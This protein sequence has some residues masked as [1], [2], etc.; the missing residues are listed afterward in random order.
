M[1][2]NIKSAPGVQKVLASLPSSNA[3]RRIDSAEPGQPAGGPAFSLSIED[4][5]VINKPLPWVGWE[6]GQWCICI[7]GGAGFKAG[8]GTLLT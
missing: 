6:R 4:K 5:A 2:I 1:E 7:G 3:E 8:R